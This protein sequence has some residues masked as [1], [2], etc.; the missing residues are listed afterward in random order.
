MHCFLSVGKH[1]EVGSG[2]NGKGVGAGAEVRVVGGLNGCGEDGNVLGFCSISL[3]LL[4][5]LLR[6]WFVLVSASAVPCC[7]TGYCGI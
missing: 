1:G 7:G 5:A 3:L 2:W 6:N 4:L